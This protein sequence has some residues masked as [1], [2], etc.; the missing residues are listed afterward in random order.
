MRL[1]CKGREAGVGRGVRVERLEP[2]T[3]FA[4][5]DLDAAF[6]TAGVAMADTPIAA[7]LSAPRRL[8]DGK[9]LALGSTGDQAL[10]RFTSTGLLDTTFGDGGRLSV[11]RFAPFDT[12]R[13]AAYLPDGKV[14][15]VGHNQGTVTGF[16]AVR[17]NADGSLDT[18][19]GAG[20]SRFVPVPGMADPIDP[21]F[22]PNDVLPLGAQVTGALIGPWSKLVVTGVTGAGLDPF[23]A[24][25]TSAGAIE[26]TFSGDGVATLAVSGAQAYARA[27]PQSDGRLVVATDGTVVR[28]NNDGTQDPTFG[29][30]AAAGGVGALMPPDHTVFTQ[31]GRAVDK[32]NYR[33]FVRGKITGALNAPRLRVIEQAGRPAVFYSRE[34]LSVGIVGQ[35][36]DGVL[37]Y[38]AGTATDLMTALVLHAVPP[39]KPA[40]RPAS[41]ATTAPTP[42]APT[43]KPTAKPP[44][45]AAPAK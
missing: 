45:P 42:R 1:G 22:P 11:K 32:F 38:S 28:F 24:R 20:G 17:L 6:G 27:V 15:V 8:A 30:G 43:A 40:T 44:K 14:I 7:S 4:A 41:G 35:P 36:V 37:G 31:A 13:A 2:R 18:T 16:T 33:P 25:L 29:A 19:Y 23:V 3:L 9:F 12:A 5:G 34:D 39:P 26:T 10:V 21:T